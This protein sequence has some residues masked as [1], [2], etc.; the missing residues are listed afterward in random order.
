M[1]CRSPLVG[2]YDHLGKFTVKRPD[3]ARPDAVAIDCGVCRDCRLAKARDWAIRCYHEAQM[4]DDVHFVDL[5][6][7]VDPISIS[8]FDLQK[9]F[10]RLR[11]AGY[12]FRYFAVGEY[13]E[14][15]GRPHYHCC[16]FGLRLTDLYPWKKSKKGTLLYRSPTLEKYWRKGHV[17]VSTFSPEAA[18]YAARYTLKKITGDL[19]DEHYVRKINGLEI[20]IQPEFQMQSLRPAI[21]RAWIEKYWEQT[22]RNGFVTYAGKKLPIPKYYVTWLAAHH[23]AV[24][25]KVVAERKLHAISKERETGKRQHQAAKARDAR[26]KNLTRNYDK[27]GESYSAHG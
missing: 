14:N 1:A 19:K 13:G 6:F 23:P 22:F 2:Y 9:F 7:A 17:T 12:K 15:F 18:G 20:R 3:L 4:H 16:L 8:K 5:T 26:T 27:N 21:G 11:R 10:K 25:E 24:H